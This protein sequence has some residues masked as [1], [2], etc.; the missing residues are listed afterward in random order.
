MPIR[1]E[2][3]TLMQQRLK[4][5]Q[6]REPALDWTLCSSSRVGCQCTR[7]LTAPWGWWGSAETWGA[8]FS[9]RVS[10]PARPPPPR[11]RIPSSSLFH[12]PLPLALCRAGQ[13]GDVCIGGSGGDLDAGQAASI[14]AACRRN[15]LIAA[16]EEGTEAGEGLEE[17]EEDYEDP[18]EM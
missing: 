18:E 5:P 2:N 15:Q 8:L 4:S 16:F 10:P 11:R 12:T 13:I 17:G 6:P 7:P 14:R 9:A 3:T 1:P